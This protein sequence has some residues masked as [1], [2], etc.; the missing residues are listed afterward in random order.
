MG[1]PLTARHCYIG[2][3]LIFKKWIKESV[4]SNLKSYHMLTIFYWFM[5]TKSPSFWKNESSCI[6]E[7]TLRHLLLYASD[8]LESG[9]IEHYFIRTINLVDR[10]PPLNSAGDVRE[11]MKKT[12]SYLKTIISDKKFPRKYVYDQT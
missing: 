4:P 11:E 12:S 9:H 1:L 3:K 7:V 2:L 6:F 8:K 10:I 5:E